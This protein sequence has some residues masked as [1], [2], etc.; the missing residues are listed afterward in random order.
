MMVSR[1]VAPEGGVLLAKQAF[2]RFR[3]PDYV[4]PMLPAVALKVLAMSRQP[5]LDL[6]DL[7]TTIESDP[8]LAARVLRLAQ[9]PIY[10]GRSPARSI[11]EAAVRLGVSGV[12][13]LLLEVAMVA[14]VFRAP[15]YDVAMRQVQIH[16]QTVAHTSRHVARYAGL[17][18]DDVFL[19][20]L[21]HDVGT[22]AILIML[23]E[24][25]I[26][27]DEKQLLEILPAAHAQVSGILARSWSFS[28]E[29]QEAVAG[30]HESSAHQPGSRLVNVL[31]VADWLALSSAAPTILEPTIRPVRALDAL[32][33]SQHTLT[34]LAADTG[35]VR[36]QL[37]DST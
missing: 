4:P 25:R 30:H 20:A 3:R 7:A 32:G 1:F 10:A 34:K 33:L 16:S 19:P 18:A 24:T 36:V 26:T 29:I 17:D 14:R 12:S 2:E 11:T 15:G 9:A 5:N 13:H 27:L 37:G 35:Q 31:A 28:P 22:A 21:L 8:M 6:R 23:S